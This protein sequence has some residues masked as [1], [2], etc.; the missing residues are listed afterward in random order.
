[1]TQVFHTISRRTLLASTAGLLAA[2]A[3]VRAQDANGVALVVGNSKY[4]WEAS[5]PNV[6]RD[7]PNIASRFQELGLRTELLQDAGKDAM[8]AGLEKFKGLL[9]CPA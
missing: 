8:L 9:V 6:K 3:I 1:M 7:A 2:P 5:L 4:K